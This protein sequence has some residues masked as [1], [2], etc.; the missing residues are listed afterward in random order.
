MQNYKDASA[1]LPMVFMGEIHQVFQLLA[2]FS[3]N[4]INTNKVELGG[5]DLETKQITSV[6][7]FALKFISK[8]F[9]HIK[10]NFLSKHIPTFAKS[11]FIKSPTVGPVNQS[12]TNPSTK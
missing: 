6:V 2:L 9:D 1:H 4:S 11:L 8:M 5:T 12:H 3:Q 10:E 7:K